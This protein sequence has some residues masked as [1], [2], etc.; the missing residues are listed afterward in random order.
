[1][2]LRY[3]HYNEA[4]EELRAAVRR[5]STEAWL[6]RG[7]EPGERPPQGMLDLARLMRMLVGAE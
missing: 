1:M 3:I 6:A 2:Q 4:R 5:R 7:E